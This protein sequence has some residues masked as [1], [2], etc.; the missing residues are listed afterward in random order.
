MRNIKFPETRPHVD[1]ADPT[2]K[3]LMERLVAAHTE[4]VSDAT[5]ARLLGYPT[6]AAFRQ[7]VKRRRCPVPIFSIDKRRGK[8]ALTCEVATWLHRCNVNAS[9]PIKTSKG[10]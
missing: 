1:S 7:A 5:L 6:T 8:F 3:A 10:K 4:I 2:F 9:H